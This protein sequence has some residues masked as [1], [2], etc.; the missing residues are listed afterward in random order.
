MKI[1]YYVQVLSTLSVCLGQFGLR[2]GL[3]ST[4]NCRA[5]AGRD[6]RRV[7]CAI[8]RLETVYRWLDP[9]SRNNGYCVFESI[10]GERAV[11]ASFGHSPIMKYDRI[12]IQLPYSLI[13]HNAETGQVETPRLEYSEM[14]CLGYKYRY[15]N[16]LVKG[17]YRERYNPHQEPPL[18]AVHYVSG[19][20]RASSSNPLFLCWSTLLMAL[21]AALIC[22]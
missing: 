11:F 8:V 10:D 18:S 12:K 2:P 6:L 3:Q 17:V 22:R 21:L 14:H 5:I 15:L 16:D 7:G 13:G 4:G 9:R 20:M 19:P 1:F